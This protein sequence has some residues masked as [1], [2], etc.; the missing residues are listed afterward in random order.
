[1]SQQYLRIVQR[2]AI[3][4]S[5]GHPISQKTPNFDITRKPADRLIAM[6][7][8]RQHISNYDN[9]TSRLQRVLAIL[10]M[11]IEAKHLW[12]EVTLFPLWLCAVFCGHG[13]LDSI[14]IKRMH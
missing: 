11:T 10:L 7:I 9:L 4:I 2:N 3:R 6:E 8:L 14:F 13:Y 1:M 12:S 5:E